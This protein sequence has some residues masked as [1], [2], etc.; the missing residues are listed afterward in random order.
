MM[1]TLPGV[2]ALEADAE[3]IRLYFHEGE[4]FRCEERPFSPWFVAAEEV[5]GAKE[6][7]GTLPLR[8]RVPG[9]EIPKNVAVCSFKEKRSAAMID[10]GIRLF[11][12]MSFDQLRRMQFQVKSTEGVIEKIS[13]ADSQKWYE[14]FSG[15]ESEIINSF[16]NAIRERDP[17]VIEGYDFF[18]N[19]WEILKKAA[20][21]KKIKLLCGRDGS[22]VTSSRSSVVIGER[23]LSYT[24]FECH[25]RHLIDV[26]LMLQ[27]HDVARR[28]LESYDLE[29]AAEFFEL[30]SEKEVLQIGELS[31]LLT[32]AY[33][34]CTNFIPGSYQDIALR[35]NG[36]KID[37]LLT[38]AYLEQNHALPLPEPPVFFP[39]ATSKVE[40]S[41]IFSPVWHCDVR[42][43]YPSIIL[44]D[45]FV[46]ARDELKLFPALLRE[47]R[48]KRLE[49]KDKAKRLSG[50][51]KEH[52][53][54]MQ[55]ALKIVINSFYGYLGF[56]QGSFND[57]AL[58]AKV[59]AKG[60][61][62]LAQMSSFLDS[63]GAQ[64]IE[65][66]TDGIYF[67]P[68][69]GAEVEELE[70][71]I[72]E[73][74]PQGIA[75]ELDA[76][77]PAMYSYKAKNYAL[78]TSDGEIKLTGAALKSRGM[79]RY[80]RGVI[81]EILRLKL[82]GEEEKINQYHQSC[83]EALSTHS[84]PLAELCKNE[85]LNDTPANYKKKLESGSSRRS[86]VY[87]LL[88]KADLPGRVGDKVE[89]YITGS[90]AKVSVVDNS[91]LLS[92]NSGE[93]DENL[94]LYLAKLD[95]LFSTF[96]K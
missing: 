60:R 40:R 28:E 8:Y 79:E 49:A 45:N 6:L 21:R 92:E 36:S 23:R 52:W 65:M 14:E 33:F 86:A 46:P 30:E 35:G 62:I 70:S 61:E 31:A 5:E 80:F 27:L 17:D 59:T 64:I 71:K 44:A 96:A 43:L 50:S 53:N 11:G 9:T 26:F 89:Y 73:I 63:S 72:Q 41:G 48:Q 56:A 81:K 13:C 85:T 95:E 47:L 20:S 24:K 4:K 94:P 38:G 32:P 16:L 69:P 74:L 75:I 58:A 84:V 76:V 7:S 77:F 57:F 54:A 87:E 88:I 91:K 78:L 67:T 82:T 2:V 19:D 55:S 34:Y 29:Y 37:L 22:A 18:R 90:K 66:D 42:S 15:E 25:G 3:K 93:R 1:G 83:R 39:G 10:S 51:E 68:P 12:G